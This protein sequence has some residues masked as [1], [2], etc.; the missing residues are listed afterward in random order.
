MLHQTLS[1]G[2]CGHGSGLLLGLI[3]RARGGLMGSSITLRSRRKPV[4]LPSSA[5]RRSSPWP[6]SPS[7]PAS[8]ARGTS[9][10]SL[11]RTCAPL[12]LCCAPRGQ[13]NRRIRALEPELRAL[14]RAL[15]PRTRLSFGRLSSDGHDPP[16][17]HGEGE[18][19]GFSQRPGS[20]TCSRGTGWGGI[21]RALLG[22]V[23]E[24]VIKH[25]HSLS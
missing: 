9:G 22:S 1:K 11:L 10:A 14:Q 6:S 20:P 19:E 5:T 17:G 3:A 25:A 15:R 18:G 16:P 13:L 21:R 23:S 8:A 4:A 12:P 7:G 2:W 24:S